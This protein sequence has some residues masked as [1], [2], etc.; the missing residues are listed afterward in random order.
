MAM[1]FQR[2]R[3]RRYRFDTTGEP[4]LEVPL[5]DAYLA[6]YYPLSEDA[7]NDRLDTVGAIDLS[8]SGTPPPA[9]FTGIYGDGNKFI[10]SDLNYLLAASTDMSSGTT[11][12][13]FSAWIQI[14]CDGAGDNGGLV[15]YYGLAGFGFQGIDA[16]SYRVV[17][18]RNNSWGTTQSGALDD[19]AWHHVLCLIEQNNIH[20]A[21]DGL[22]VG[23]PE[24]AVSWV[25]GTSNLS[26]A[27]SLVSPV[28]WY[29]LG[30]I[31]EVCIWDSIP[32]FTQR[33]FQRLAGALYNGGDGVF[34][35]G[36]NWF[37]V[38]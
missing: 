27:L 35:D 33:D 18:I 31:D 28:A 3:A 21:V 24:T 5:W 36:A 10:D 37:E 22:E 38:V 29:P 9:A 7:A 14:D 34:Y 12:L 20:L 2:Q 8:P 13:L 15:S 32:D 26:I 4:L 17:P 1:Q 6:H 11:N 25:M 23:T 19:T 16:S 30:V